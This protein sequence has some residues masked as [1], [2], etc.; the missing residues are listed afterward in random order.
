M[1][2]LLEARL[3]SADTLV[4][5]VRPFV[6]EATTEGAH[7]EAYVVDSGSAQSITPIAFS[8]AAGGGNFVP[9]GHNTKAWAKSASAYEAAVLTDISATLSGPPPRDDT[10][11]D[12]VGAVTRGIAATATMSGSGR[13]RSARLRDPGPRLLLPRNGLPAKSPRHAA[14]KTDRGGADGRPRLVPWRGRL[15]P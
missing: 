15:F 8:A 7:V 6:H 5:R 14:A 12:L 13:S 11:A 3:L 1:A 10:G 4:D 9:R 2:A